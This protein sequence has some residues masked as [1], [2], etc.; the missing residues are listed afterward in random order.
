MGANE[1]AGEQGPATTLPGGQQDGFGNVEGCFSAQ[2]LGDCVCPHED[3]SRNLLLAPLF[4]RRPG[5]TGAL[6]SLVA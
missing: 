4:L 1:Q 5:G 6:V 3:W 2:Q